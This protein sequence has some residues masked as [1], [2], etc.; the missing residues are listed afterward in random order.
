MTFGNNL[1]FLSGGRV[2]QCRVWIAP[3][4]FGYRSLNWVRQGT[5]LWQCRNGKR[6]RF[7]APVLFWTWPGPVFSYGTDNGRPWDHSWISFK[8]TKADHL[9]RRLD[10]AQVADENFRR[11]IDVRYASDTF[12]RL[13]A[14]L[15]QPVQPIDRMTNLIE[16][17]LLMIRESAAMPLLPKS[18][19]TA[20]HDPALEESPRH[21]RLTRL[22]QTIQADPGKKWNW[23]QE[24][25]RLCI[26]EIHFRRLFQKCLGLPPQQYLIRC[27]L[28]SA[29]DQLTHT[30]LPV[31]TI[32]ITA[33][34]SD[35]IHFTKT[36]RR[37][38]GLTP[39][40][41]R[42]EMQRYEEVSPP[43]ADR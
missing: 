19:K 12:D 42:Q 14:C 1:R 23:E 21:E 38:H 18:D 35:A 6:L 2:P 8:G 10:V 32:G 13:L 3:R 22:G 7:S 34:Y 41:Y 29:A 33:G 40:A 36:F 5:I 39:T 17:L 11:P 16:S 20:H 15:A 37:H 24:S 26:S 28:K 27:R 31:K 25:R 9:F 4:R 30:N 43:D